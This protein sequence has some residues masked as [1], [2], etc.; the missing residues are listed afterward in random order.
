[1][2]FLSRLF[3]SC[4]RITCNLIYLAGSSRVHLDYGGAEAY[5]VPDV[6]Q[7]S[8]DD[9]GRGA[10]GPAAR[11]VGNGNIVVQAVGSEIDVTVSPHMP[12]LRLTLFDVASLAFRR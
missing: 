7:A 3:L 6:S 10:A 8:K 2:A 1:V 4:G 12:H 11:V 9:Q 5:A